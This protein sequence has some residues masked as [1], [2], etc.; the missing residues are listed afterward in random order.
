M[1]RSSKRNTP[2]GNKGSQPAQANNPKGRQVTGNI[3]GSPVEREVAERAV[4]ETR[5]GSVETNGLY[6]ID[7]ANQAPEVG[8]GTETRLSLRSVELR[9]VSGSPAGGPDTRRASQASVTSRNDSRSTRVGSE[10]YRS[11][12]S[13][14]KET[15]QG[16][17]KIKQVQCAW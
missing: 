4:S 6:A 13:P 3:R 8:D 9:S 2:N 14:P 12:S 16:R 15:Q 1:E 10:T 5:L 17:L 7:E 11:E